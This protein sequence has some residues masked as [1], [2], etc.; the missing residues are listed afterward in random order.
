MRCNRSS[1]TA[2]AAPIAESISPASSK[3][4]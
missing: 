1:P 4:R 3:C 2:V